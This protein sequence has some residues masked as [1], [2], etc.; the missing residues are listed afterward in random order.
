M[1]KPILNQEEREHI[2]HDTH[3]GSYLRIF[4][5]SKKL[6]REMYRDYGCIGVWILKMLTSTPLKYKEDE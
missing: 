1:K 4:I 3:R 5:E 6:Q 2:K